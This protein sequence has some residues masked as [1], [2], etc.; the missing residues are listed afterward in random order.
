MPGSRAGW[1]QPLGESLQCG[2]VVTRIARN[3]WR[4]R[5]RCLRHPAPAPGAMAGRALHRRPAGLRRRARGREPAGTAAPGR[6]ARCA[7][8]L[9][10][11]PTCICARRW[12]TAPAPRRAGTTWSTAA[13]VW[14]TW[15]PA[16]S[17][18]DPTPR[19]TVISWY[20]PLG[21]EPPR[22]RRRP[23]PVAGAPLDPLARRAAG[24]ALPAASGPAAN[25]PRESR[26]RATAMPWPCPCRACWL[27]PSG[28]SA[29][30]RVAGAWRFAHADW[31]GYSIFEEAFTRGHFA[32]EGLA[33]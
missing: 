33:G 21:T 15:T 5:S 11:W 28:R 19:A 16:T 24:R 31:S 13:E 20:R 6:H 18:L 3:A 23:P 1:R 29:P 9:G 7:M 14:A 30:H 2:Q 17:A 32:G 10:W 22:R 26:S 27:A 4:H 8:R 12:P 25:W